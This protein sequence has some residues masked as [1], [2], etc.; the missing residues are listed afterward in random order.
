VEKAEESRYRV[1]L[2]PRRVVIRFQPRADAGSVAV[3]LASMTCKYLREVCMI[4][5]N[6]FWAAR[7]RGLKETAGYPVDAGRFL[8]DIRPAMVAEGIAEAAVWRVK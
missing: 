7:V 2:L 3:A 6:A 5:F 1:E 8:A 4:Q